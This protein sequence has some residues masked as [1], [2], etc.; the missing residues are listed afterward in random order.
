MSHS[1]LCFAQN[2]DSHP[3]VFQCFGEALL[4][5][6]EKMFWRVGLSEYSRRRIDS[7]FAFQ[8]IFDDRITI[9]LF[10][11]H[12]VYFFE[13]EKK[14]CSKWI[15]INWLIGRVA[16]LCFIYLG[17]STQPHTDTHTRYHI[18][19]VIMFL[20]F[21]RGVRIRRWKCL[22]LLKFSWIAVHKIRSRVDDIQGADRPIE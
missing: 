7:I 16:I 15:H 21:W 19:Y 3:K 18:N 10:S 5:S 13:S 2:I 17:F 12:F 11:I 22:K 4:R 8:F 9:C 1:I 6:F 20:S 14:K